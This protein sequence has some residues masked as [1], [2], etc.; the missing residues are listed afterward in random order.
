MGLLAFS[1]AE[2]DGRRQGPAQPRAPRA[3]RD[4]ALVP[5]AAYLRA[6]AAAMCGV[7]VLYVLLGLCC[8]KR[9]KKHQEIE[10]RKRLAQNELRS[11][12]VAELANRQNSPSA[13]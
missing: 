11:A 10:Y 9:L 6:C 1:A 4:D 2:S 7:G 8:C 5:Y 12:Y 3:W 13:V